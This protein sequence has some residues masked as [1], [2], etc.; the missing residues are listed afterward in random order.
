ML[1]PNITKAVILARGLGKRMRRVD[2][3]A[4]AALA[5][6]Q[7]RAA[8][9]G[10]KAMIPVGRPFL[11]F[12]LSALAD[13]GFTDACLVIGPEHTAV[14]EYYGSIPLRRINVSFAIQESAIGTANAALAAQAFTG[15]EEFLVLNSDNYYPVEVFTA[16][17][18]LGEPGLPAFARDAL[19]RC[20][21]IPAERICDY[22]V[23]KI[24][25]EGY[26]DE[27]VEK[28]KSTDSD[29]D[30]NAKTGQSPQNPPNFISMNC[31]RFDAA[32]FRACA[33][34]PISVRGEFELPEAVRYGMNALGL[35][36]RALPVH[37]GVLDL[38]YRGDISEVT[39]RLAGVDVNL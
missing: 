19:A 20:G 1:D 34:V 9:S 27:I 24:S 10:M 21:N 32:I 6:E 7:L 39:H 25:A 14:R 15:S 4:P 16:M 38:S 11:D 5:S 18:T 35:K 31:W 37:A 23:L 33:E 17:R 22:A 2:A 30:A 36:F 3:N 28:P 12:V 8:D 26:L 29:L 13:A